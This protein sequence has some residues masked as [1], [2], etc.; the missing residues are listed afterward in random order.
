MKL[1]ASEVKLVGD[2]KDF[3]NRDVLVFEA[4]KHSSVALYNLLMEMTKMSKPGTDLV[5]FELQNNLGTYEVTEIE[6]DEEDY[7]D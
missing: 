4:P 2:H 5:V 6:I 1:A 7:E 3:L